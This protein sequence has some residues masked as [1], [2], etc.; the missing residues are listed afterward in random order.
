CFTIGRLTRCLLL[1][2]HINADLE[3]YRNK[4]KLILTKQGRIRTDAAVNRETGVLRHIFRKAVEWEL[5]EESP[6]DRGKSLQ[7][8]ENNKRIRYLTE[9]KINR[10]LKECKDTPHLY[11]I[12]ACALNTG[13]R[14][15]EILNLKWDQVR[16]GFI[17]LQKT[18]TNEPREIPIN[19]DLDAVLKDIRKE[20]Q[21]RSKYVFTYKGLTIQRVDRAFKAALKRA[22]IEDFK[23][24]DLRHTFASHAIMRG[25]SMKEVQE[26]LGHKSF[27]MTMRYA[28][29][30][31]EHKNKAVNLLNGLTASPNSCDKNC[32]KTVTSLV[33][34]ET[35]SG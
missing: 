15:K 20:Q 3:T 4:L 11:R 12:V 2:D 33:S 32:H 19:D 8:K 34:Q 10:L 1:L 16:N 26:L 24:H 21:F 17:Y 7:L 28:H 23:F 22:V 30:S 5:T 31:Q 35:V 25:A 29:L 18:K 14:R 9:E 13:M 6:F 27:S